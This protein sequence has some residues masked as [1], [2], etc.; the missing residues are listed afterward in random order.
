MVRL[1]IL[2][3]GKTPDQGWNMVLYEESAALVRELVDGVSTSEGWILNPG[4]VGLLRSLRRLTAERASAPG[5]TGSSVAA[6]VAHLLYGFE[7]LNR[8]ARGPDA[9]AADYSESWRHGRVDERGWALLCQRLEAEL[10]TWLG[11]LAEPREIDPKEAKGMLASLAHLA[12]HF[13]AIRQIA[14]EAKGPKAEAKS[15]AP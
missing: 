7:L 11:E 1:R 6:H 2:G 15:T 14:P 10:R 9:F 12:Y 8:R 4:D 13:G 3:Y 5:P